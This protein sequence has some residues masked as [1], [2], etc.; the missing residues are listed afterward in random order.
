MPDDAVYVGRPSNWGNPFSTAAEFRTL[1]EAIVGISGQSEFHKTD[2]A[3]FSRV[4]WMAQNVGH[5]R[6]KKLA[7]W[8]GLDHDC[9]ADALAEIANRKEPQ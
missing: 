6:G 8:C 2:L 9:H 1:L 4:Y 5:L 7:C 3:S